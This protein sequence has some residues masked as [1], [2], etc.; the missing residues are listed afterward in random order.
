MSILSCR[1]HCA[2]LMSRSPLCDIRRLAILRSDGTTGQHAAAGFDPLQ[3]YCQPILT[4]A[5][6]KPSGHK[7]PWDPAITA[8]NDDS[9]CPGSA[10]AHMLIST[11]LFVKLPNSAALATMDWNSADM[12]I[13]SIAAPKWP[14]DL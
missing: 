2:A 9:R 12:P 8:V 1:H 10:N 13:P 4:W 14:V 5:R 3:I 7:V 6:Q 11:R